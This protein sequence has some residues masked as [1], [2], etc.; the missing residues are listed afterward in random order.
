[1]RGRILLRYQMSNEGK[2]FKNSLIVFSNQ[3]MD[4][5]LLIKNCRNVETFC[6]SLKLSRPLAVCYNPKIDIQNGTLSGTWYY[7]HSE[8][9]WTPID[10]S[11]TTTYPHCSDIKELINSNK[12]KATLKYNVKLSDC[13]DEVKLEPGNNLSQYWN[14]LWCVVVSLFTSIIKANS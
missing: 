7:G 5:Y 9:Q 1:M 2:A 13:P 11:I 6:N 12:N 8:G 4:F 14:C 3:P 10:F